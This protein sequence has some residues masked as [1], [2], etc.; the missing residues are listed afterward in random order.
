MGQVGINVPIP[1]PVP[2]FSFS[3]SR[4]SKLGDLGPYGKQAIQFYTQAKT[5]TARW[6]D[7]ATVHPGIHTTI[8]LK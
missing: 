6:F 4:G 1:V 8:S 3:G 7:D 5:V 2:A